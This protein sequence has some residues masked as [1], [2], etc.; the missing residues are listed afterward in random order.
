MIK[1]YHKINFF[2][3]YFIKLIMKYIIH[4]GIT[5]KNI[6]E[7]SYIAIKKA[8]KDKI[9]NISN[10]KLLVLQKFENADSLIYIGKGSKAPNVEIRFVFETKGKKP[11]LNEITMRP[12]EMKP[13]A[14]KK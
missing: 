7:N 8:I 3:I 13:V 9:G 6:K 10:A 12:L 11:L 1:C 14:E 5:S 4:R 2:S